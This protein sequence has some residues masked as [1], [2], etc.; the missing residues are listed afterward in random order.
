MSQVAIEY[1][2][3]LD[4]EEA[5][6]MLKIHPK[7]LQKLARSGE[8]SGVQ[9]GKLWRFCVSALNAWLAQKMIPKSDALVNSPYST[10]NG[11]GANRTTAVRVASMKRKKRGTGS[12]SK[13]VLSSQ[14]A[15]K[16]RS[17][18]SDGETFN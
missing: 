6:A 17:A 5:A 13:E 15:R 4:S 14:I 18:S 1:E 2:P 3:L 10:L 7:T 8:I 11:S 12:T 16:G 9:I